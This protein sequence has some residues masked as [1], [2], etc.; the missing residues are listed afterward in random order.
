L[1]VGELYGLELVPEAG[2]ADGGGAHF[3]AA[4]IAAVAD[5]TGIIHLDPR[6]QLV[7]EAKPVGQAELFEIDVLGGGRGVVVGDARVKGQSLGALD[8]L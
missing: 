1:D 2:H 3:A 5:P 6:P 8:G 7:G 4:A